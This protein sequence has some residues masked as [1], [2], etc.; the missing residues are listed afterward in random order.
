[1]IPLRCEAST[2]SGF[3][4]QLAVSYIAKGYWFYVTG[5]IPVGK[6]PLPVDAKLTTRYGV[7]GSKWV[8]CRRKKRGIANVQYLRFRRFFMLLATSGESPLFLHECVHDIRRKPVHC[9]GYTIGCY[10]DRRGLWRPSVRIEKAYF[11]DLRNQLVRRAGSDS[12][13]ALL[14]ELQHLPFEPYAPVRRQL[15][16]L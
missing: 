10:R 14:R 12:M 8:R 16:S 13:D 1:M 2:V 11:C 5:C 9:F 6:E 4:Q 3:I 15:L 7:S